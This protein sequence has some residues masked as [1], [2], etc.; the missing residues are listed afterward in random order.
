M[1]KKKVLHAWIIN[2]RNSLLKS[3][4]F[5]LSFNPGNFVASVF[6]SDGS[7]SETALC[8][9]GNYFILNGDHRA[10]YEKVFDQGFS[11]CF[12]YFMKHQDQVSSWSDDPSEAGIG[13]IEAAS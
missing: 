13:Y 8:K 5:Y 7:G 2:G 4:D 3:D 1:T 6:D 10:A 9:D 12:A 11:A